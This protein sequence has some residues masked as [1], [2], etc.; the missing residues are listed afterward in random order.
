MEFTEKLYHRCLDR[1][2]TL[3]KMRLRTLQMEKFE[4]YIKLEKMEKTLC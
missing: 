2:K 1:N 4:T 3:E